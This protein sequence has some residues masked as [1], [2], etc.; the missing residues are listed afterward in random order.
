MFPQDDSTTASVDRHIPAGTGGAMQASTRTEILLETI[1]RRL[2]EI[3]ERQHALAV[4]RARLIDQITPLRL[5]IT[6]PEVALAQLRSRGI[7]LRGVAAAWSADHPAESGVLR[8]IAPPP[9]GRVMTLP[10]GRSET[11]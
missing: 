9:R 1:E 2:A 8:A 6:S 10:T 11:A 4:E 7:V 5:G 3:S